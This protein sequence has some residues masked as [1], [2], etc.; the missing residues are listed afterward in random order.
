MAVKITRKRKTVLSVKTGKVMNGGAFRGA[1]HGRTKRSMRS[2][3]FSGIPNPFDSGRMRSGSGSLRG[4]PGSPTIIVV[5]P[6]AG[7]PGPHLQRL[8]GALLANPGGTSPRIK[9]PSVQKLIS[10]FSGLQNPRTLRRAAIN[11]GP[12]SRVSNLVKL[13]TQPK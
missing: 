12:S 3:S 13:F 9:S 1:R 5:N 7:D 8:T 10:K 2:R 6:S 11:T 4:V